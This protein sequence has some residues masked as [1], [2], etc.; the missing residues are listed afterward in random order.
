MLVAETNPVIRAFR[1]ASIG[2]GG[3]AKGGIPDRFDPVHP[4]RLRNPS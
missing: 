3:D 1:T 4:E 2:C